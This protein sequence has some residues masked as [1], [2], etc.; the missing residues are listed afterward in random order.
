MSSIYLET[1]IIPLVL[2]LSFSRAA[3]VGIV[4]AFLF[5]VVIVMTVVFIISF[6][7]RRFYMGTNLVN[8]ITLIT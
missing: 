1:I 5:L 6:I 2:I 3:I 7:R 4:L 8:I